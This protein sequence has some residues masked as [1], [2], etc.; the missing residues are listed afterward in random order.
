MGGG[1]GAAGE[2]G[3]PGA[4]CVSLTGCLLAC[5]FRFIENPL[6]MRKG[7][8]I[9]RSQNSQVFIDE[10]MKSPNIG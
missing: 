6:R 1:E 2:L 10:F 3:S 7:L 4:L 5:L 8:I 9:C